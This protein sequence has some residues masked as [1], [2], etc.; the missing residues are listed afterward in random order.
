MPR[1]RKRKSPARRLAAEAARIAHALHCRDIVVLD[2]GGISPVTDAFVIA[3]GTSGRQMAAVAQ[4]ITD[5][6]A[7]SGN[8]LF[9]AEG[10]TSGSWILL[11]FVDVIVHIFDEAHRRYYDLELIWGDAPRVR[12]RRTRT[13]AGP[14]AKGTGD[15]A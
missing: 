5:A 6:A 9:G 8:A 10:L 1:A 15:D 13:A 11:D 12:W 14:P 2:L 7:A 3:T 4:K